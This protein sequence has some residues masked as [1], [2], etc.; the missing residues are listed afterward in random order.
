MTGIKKKAI[1]KIFGWEDKIP[2]CKNVNQDLF[3]PTK[4]L[5]ISC[6]SANFIANTLYFL[7]L[8][9]WSNNSEFF[10]L[11]TPNKN[12]TKKVEETVP[13]GRTR[14]PRR[15]AKTKK[16]YKDLSNSESESEQE[17]SHSFKE[18]LLV[19]VIDKIQIKNFWKACENTKYRIYFC[20]NVKFITF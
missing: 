7:Y 11:K 8:R 16:N 6:Y 18:K 19:K 13:D 14:L 1:E 5:C 20:E 9:Y 4:I 15:A 3:I 12:I 2:S 17:F 10:L